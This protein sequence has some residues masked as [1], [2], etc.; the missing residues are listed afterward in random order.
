MTKPQ[1]LPDAKAILGYLPDVDELNDLADCC[2]CYQLEKRQGVLHG[3][4]FERSLDAI[5]DRRFAAE[6]K[7]RATFSQNSINRYKGW[8][9]TKVRR[10]LVRLLYMRYR[11]DNRLTPTEANIRIMNDHVPQIYGKKKVDESTITRLT[12]SVH[13]KNLHK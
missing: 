1:K 12:A 11:L 7:D 13:I 9:R 2:I 6:K 3:Y 4:Y 10:A 8:A 5:I